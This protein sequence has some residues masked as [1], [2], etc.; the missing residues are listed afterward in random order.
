MEIPSTLAK[1]GGIIYYINQFS[2]Q[3][4]RISSLCLLHST[5]F[6]LKDYIEQ[7]SSQPYD[8]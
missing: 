4:L 1:I 2:M 6:N 3:N 5:I 8:L 7:A